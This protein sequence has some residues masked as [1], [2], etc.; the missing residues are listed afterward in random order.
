MFD[1]KTSFFLHDGDSF[2]Q[3]DSVFGLSR[4]LRTNGSVALRQTQKIEK[5]EPSHPTF[6]L[7]DT[8]ACSHR[9]EPRDLRTGIGELIVT[10]ASAGFV[11]AIANDAWTKCKG[12]TDFTLSSREKIDRMAAHNLAIL[13]I[14]AR[15]HQSG[16]SSKFVCTNEQ[17]V[18][19]GRWRYSYRDATYNYEVTIKNRDGRP[20]VVT[21]TRWQHT[22]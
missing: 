18:R 21:V 17:K 2:L 15:Y 16:A 10:A 7:V 14:V 3:C 13:H 19:R 20:S 11:G 4:V 12:I 6:N 8:E 22:F 9:E 1:S 5:R